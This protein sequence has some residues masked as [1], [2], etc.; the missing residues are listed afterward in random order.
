MK[1]K[2]FLLI[3]IVISLSTS[4][5]PQEAAACENGFRPYEH[6]LGET[7]IPENP[8]Q[9]ASLDI[10]IY[11]LLL[12]TGSRP[13]VHTE[14]LI[15]AFYE[16]AHPELLEEI[17]NINADIPDIGFPPNFEVLA[18]AQPDLIIGVDDFITEEV[19]PLLSQIAPTVVISVDPGDWRARVELAG[20][21]LNITEQVDEL[22]AT[23][24]AR[25]AEFQELIGDDLATI[26][27][28]LIRVFPGQIG[29]MLTGSIADQV[30]REVGLSRPEAQVRDL[31]FVVTELGGRAEL[32]ISREDLGLANG[33][34]I[35]IFGAPDELIDDPLWQRLEAVQNNQSYPVG[36][37]W[38]VDGLISVHDMLDDLFQHVAG[39]KSTVPNPFE[40][41]LFPTDLE[42]E[43][44]HI[45]SWAQL[46]WPQP[47][48]Q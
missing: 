46:W 20:D 3:M 35:F 30:I 40:D 26:E 28:S 2:F 5:Y 32:T 1:H 34:I 29:I 4:V 7:C 39:T 18:E 45:P 23:Y 48:I 14:I 17:Q 41:S 36:Y 6:A 24:D 10:T 16:R 12:I 44:S 19:Y 43:E 8:Q 15:N 9:V 21:A 33:D 11:E 38:Y 13:A 27:I 42:T 22:L 31:D 37:Y 47:S 25:V